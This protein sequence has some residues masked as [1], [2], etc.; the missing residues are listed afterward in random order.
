VLAQKFTENGS[1][2][3][4]HFRIG[5]TELRN[6]IAAVTMTPSEL[7]M[8]FAEFAAQSPAMIV[9]VDGDPGVNLQTDFMPV[10]HRG[11][12]AV[13]MSVIVDLPHLVAN[14][15][16]LGGGQ[17]RGKGLKKLSIRFAFWAPK[18]VVIPFALG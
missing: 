14:G 15:R 13:K 9:L 17:V 2:V 18:I 16:A 5:E 7:R 12:E 11:L 3:V 6:V 1:F 8:L 4:S 10:L